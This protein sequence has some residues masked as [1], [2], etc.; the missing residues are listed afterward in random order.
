MRP[1][2]LH[3]SALNDYEYGFY[4]TSLQDLADQTDIKHEDLV[5]GVREV[6]A[7][8]RGRFG[9][10]PLHQIDNVRGRDIRRLIG[11]HHTDYIHTDP[12][13]ISPEFRSIRH[14][15]G[16]SV[17]C[18]AQTSAPSTIRQTD[19]QGTSFC[20]KCAKND[21]IILIVL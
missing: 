9:N 21:M 5:V 1:L 6:R 10:V 7:W 14:P 19:R 15:L 17:L 2:D 4:T 12:Q 3:I 18:R 13:T 16:W 8:L 11:V 20:T